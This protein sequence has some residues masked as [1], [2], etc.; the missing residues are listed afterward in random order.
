MES[1]VE[2]CFECRSQNAEGENKEEEVE[3]R[4]CGDK[5]ME[6]GECRV[7]SGRH[8]VG[9]ERN[10]GEGH[11]ECMIQAAL[12][13]DNNVL[14]DKPRSSEDD[15]SGKDEGS[16]KIRDD[17]N[18]QKGRDFWFDNVDARIEK[19]CT[20][21]SIE[22]SEPNLLKKKR[23]RIKKKGREKSDFESKDVFENGQ[24]DSMVRKLK[25][26]RKK[27][28]KLEKTGPEHGN[29][30]TGV[31]L[32]GLWLG[33]QFPEIKETNDVTPKPLLLP[34]TE[35]DS[36]QQHQLPYLPYSHFYSNHFLPN[37]FPNTAP[38]A[39]D[40]CSISSSVQGN[41]GKSRRKRF[42]DLKKTS[43]K[44]SVLATAPPLPPISSRLE[45]DKTARSE[46]HAEEGQDEPEHEEPLKLCKLIARFPV[47][48]FRKYF[49]SVFSKVQDNS[50]YVRVMSLLG[51]YFP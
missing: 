12:E 6:N 27:R 20:G 33:Q 39:D 16:E 34:Q 24:S 31:S 30:N 25:K 17:K 10:S 35:T 47:L 22:N 32:N 19:Q 49:Y 42:V 7:D 37:V 51:T 50:G 5:E 21:T 46:K 40:S 11:D 9:N 29:L 8:G 2:E 1:Y 45:L 43:G 15:G 18:G 26:K 36:C 23:K 48:C 38:A 14:R 4:G 13:I 3:K 41:R 44:V 28:I